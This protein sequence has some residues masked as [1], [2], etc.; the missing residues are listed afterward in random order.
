[1]TSGRRPSVAMGDLWVRPPGMPIPPHA[2]G[3]TS[4]VLAEGRAF[5][6]SRE[7][8]RGVEGHASQRRNGTGRWNPVQGLLV[9][10]QQQAGRPGTLVAPILAGI[11]PGRRFS[12]LALDSPARGKARR[13][14]SEDDWVLSSGAPG[15]EV[16][17]RVYCNPSRGLQAS[18]SHAKH[19]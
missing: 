8:R 4:P 11:K 16:G 5:G 18:R 13:Q 1:M 12:G 19:G 6:V 15:R 3:S 7:N 17:A 10:G 14:L 2:G 9:H